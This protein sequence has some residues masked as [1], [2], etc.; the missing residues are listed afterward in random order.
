MQRQRLTHSRR[1]VI[2]IGSALLTNDG[3]GLNREGIA[4]WV[5]QMAA[6]QQRGIEVVLVSSG[7]VAEG[8]ARLG[9]KT[10]PHALHELDAPVVRVRR[11]RVRRIEPEPVTGLEHGGQIGSV[12]VDDVASRHS[13]SVKMRIEPPAV[14]TYSTLPAAI[15]L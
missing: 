4:G 1:W 5:S 11:G 9:W 15:Q 12:L 2:K 14:R 8:M 13:V 3:H 6:L 7:A 10:R